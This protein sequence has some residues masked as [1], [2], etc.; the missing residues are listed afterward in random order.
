MDFT[1]EIQAIKPNKAFAVAFAALALALAGCASGLG[2]EPYVR[3]QI[4]HLS[5]ID[6]GTV[7]ASRAASAADGFAYTVRL[8][9][10]ELVSV[11][12][13]GNSSFADGTPV[14]VEY[15]A[16]SRLIPQTAAMTAV[17]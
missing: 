8:N 10:G 12:Q 7:I 16:R 15:G 2:A 5:R 1:S 4:G 13:S 11:T 14:L 6:E 17:S 3:G 9:N